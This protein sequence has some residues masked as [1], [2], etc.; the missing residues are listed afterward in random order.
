MAQRPTPV[1]SEKLSLWRRIALHVWGE[2]TS[3]TIC[4]TRDYDVEN[5]IRFLDWYNSA[6]E[7][8]VTMTALLIKAAALS[9]Q[10]YPELNR[11]IVA[12]RLYDLPTI[13]IAAPVNLGGQ[14]ETAMI[15]IRDADKKTLDEIATDLKGRVRATKETSSKLENQNEIGKIIDAVPPFILGAVVRV[16]KF[17]VTNF[18]IAELV[19]NMDMSPGSF[20]VSS[21]GMNEAATFTGL[22]LMP[23]AGMGVVGSMIVG[24]VEPKPVAEN[25]KV[26]IRHRL[27]L[28]AFFDHRA[29]DGWKITRYG[30]FWQDFLKNPG[31]FLDIE[32]DMNGPSRSKGPKT[33]KPRRGMKNK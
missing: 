11:R 10:K 20:S 4:A 16:A 25:G 2:P 9:I 14:G 13:D 23:P 27:P 1:P 30:Q 18:N 33:A 8:H 26:V 7:T 5:A 28:M 12:G 29:V 6:H 3:P 31:A 22:A 21:L 17:A 32:W 24:R 19:P 15:L